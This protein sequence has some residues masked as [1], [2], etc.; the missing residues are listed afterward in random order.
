MGLDRDQVALRMARSAESGAESGAESDIGDDGASVRREVGGRSIFS[1]PDSS[2]DEDSELKD[3]WT[4]WQRIYERSVTDLQLRYDPMRSLGLKVA[5]EEVPAVL[6]SI[7]SALR[8][9]SSASLSLSHLMNYWLY[10]FAC[11]IKKYVNSVLTREGKRRKSSTAVYD[12]IQTELAVLV[13]NKSPTV[14][15]DREYQREWFF[16]MKSRYAEYMDILNALDKP[17]KDHIIYEEDEGILEGE[18]LVQR[19]CR[20]AHV[21]GKSII[22]LDDDKLRISGSKCS[23]YGL[24]AKKIG[25]TFGPVQ[26]TVASIITGICL[27]TH[28]EKAHQTVLEC[29]TLLFRG[30]SNKQLDREV[31]IDNLITKDRG[32]NTKDTS[33]F[34]L[35]RGADELETRKREANFPFTFNR[36][37]HGEQISIPERGSMGLY[38]A[39][40]RPEVKGRSTTVL[41]GF[42]FRRFGRVALLQTSKKEYKPF[43]WHYTIDHG[44]AAENNFVHELDGMHEAQREAADKSIQEFL[45]SIC[46]L[47]VCQGTPEWFLLRRFRLT[48]SISGTVCTKWFRLA[49]EKRLGDLND[50]DITHS[51]VDSIQLIAKVVGYQSSANVGST[52]NGDAVYTAGPLEIDE[53]ER[54]RKRLLFL[55]REEL[56][57][58]CKEHIDPR[59]SWNH[60]KPILVQKLLDVGF[61]V[62]MLQE[63]NEELEFSQLLHDI[64]FMRPLQRRLL[65]VGSKN[66]AR[67]LSW[68]PSFC[69][70][71]NPTIQILKIVPFGLLANKKHGFMATSVDGIAVFSCQTGV[72]SATIEIKTRATFES[73]AVARGTAG[74][75]GKWCEV[76]PSEDPKRFQELIP[77]RNYRQQALH[78]ASVTNCRFVFFIEATVRE[79]EYVV[80]LVFRRDLLSAYRDGVLCPIYDRY[81]K[82]MLERLTDSARDADPLADSGLSANWAVDSNTYIQSF[83]LWEKLNKEIQSKKEPLPPAVSILP[84]VVDAWNNLK[85]GVDVVS[86][87]L[88]NVK[89][90]HSRMGLHGR[91]NL[92]FLHIILMNA[93][94]TLRMAETLQEVPFGV[95]WK[96]YFKSYHRYKNKLNSRRSFEQFL[97]LLYSKWKDMRS[98]PEEREG[99]YD[100]IEDSE[101][102]LRTSPWGKKNAY[103]TRFWFNTGE[104]QSFRERSR[105]SSHEHVPTRNTG[106]TAGRCIVCCIRCATKSHQSGG[107]GERRLGYKTSNCCMECAEELSKRRG[108][109]GRPEKGIPLCKRKRFG[110]NLGTCFEIHHS[111][112]AYPDLE[113]ME[114]QERALSLNRPL[115][116]G[117]PR[118]KTSTERAHTKRRI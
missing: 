87:I 10:P 77:N 117:R 115:K 28:L 47:T 14:L 16:P 109:N 30:L 54:A 88:A 96:A 83:L 3:G 41:Y 81:V 99:S 62:D 11:H 19:L 39:K 104:M 98:M 80:F 51:F 8:V 93:H 64:W 36:K 1:E 97:M 25:N 55:R 32:Y 38:C 116:R 34:C 71:H 37:P 50:M 79:I 111:R 5:E 31:V 6:S 91:I 67:V 45:E 20:A 18:K 7:K 40:L 114:G 24:A 29:I 46:R 102:N 56:R 105:S 85:G 59:M 15:F 22:A 69:H 94:L 113:C 27:G 57:R 76:D 89:D 42:A 48:S 108:E 2:S 106:V 84:A 52:N 118:G 78:H 86:R 100:E 33:L 95:S 23:L 61:K 112:G 110:E 26:H 44:K 63:P 35:A 53:Q 65:Q 92:R 66:E 43:V 49:S 75:H 70:R 73:I 13:Y 107:A 21:P 74:L 4:G 72:S 101:E 58:L 17:M 60:N 12:F 9:R 90:C 82:P 68:L 103:H